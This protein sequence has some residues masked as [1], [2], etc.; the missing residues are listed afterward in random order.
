[1]HT[2][3][4]LWPSFSD[5]LTAFLTTGQNLS[6]HSGTRPDGLRQWP[7]TTSV[8]GQLILWPMP[9]NRQTDWQTDR[10]THWSTDSTCWDTK[11]Q[12]VS[13][14]VELPLTRRHHIRSTRAWWRHTLSQARVPLL[15]RRTAPLWRCWFRTIDVH[16]AVAGAVVWDA[17]W[18]H[19]WRHTWW[20]IFDRDHR[21]EKETERTWQCW[22]ETLVHRMGNI[23]DYHDSVW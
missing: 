9:F 15:R 23:K 4:A 8:V 3:S 7:L 14:D 12:N 22:A 6:G 20:R 11:T 2:G 19:T 17:W 16:R 21:K 1:M 13:L 18:R 10:Q 5:S